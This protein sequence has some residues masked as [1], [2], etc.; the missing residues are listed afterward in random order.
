MHTTFIL[1][2]N[3]VITVYQ[4][5]EDMSVFE[6]PARDPSASYCVLIWALISVLRW[7]AVHGRIGYY[8]FGNRF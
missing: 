7:H 5:T 4:P 6:H 2:A 8:A 1:N 3:S